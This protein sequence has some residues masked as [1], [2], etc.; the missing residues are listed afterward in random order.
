MTKSFEF[1][2][3]SLFEISFIVGMLVKLEKL[4]Q[5]S[6]QKICAVKL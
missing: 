3:M 4:D 5:E 1:E 6:F 2:L